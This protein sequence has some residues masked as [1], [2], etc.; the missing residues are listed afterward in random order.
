MGAT[1]RVSTRMSEREGAVTQ[2][3]LAAVDAH[4]DIRHPTAHP[5]RPAWQEELGFVL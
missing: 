2:S 4:S 1:P 5:I 3:A